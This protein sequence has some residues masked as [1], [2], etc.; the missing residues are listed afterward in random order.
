M[1]KNKI[2]LAF[3]AI[4]LF[5]ACLRPVGNGGRINKY[6]ESYFK[7]EGKMLYFIKPVSFYSEKDKLDA[8]FTFNKGDS[9]KPMIVVNISIYGE[10]P[11]KTADSTTFIFGEQSYT[12]PISLLYNE[13]VRRTK[14]SRQT[15]ELDKK[16]FQD[17]LKAEPVEIVLYYGDE[18]K[19]YTS[20]K[21]WRKT[22]TMLH[23][24]MFW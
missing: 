16:Y 11:F 19:T 22:H 5:T 1:R 3:I 9:T 2:L 12:S 10:P 24:M 13:N 7:G 6:S 8:D 15:A 4:T 23:N 17:F 20:G 14:Y 18:K 21:Q